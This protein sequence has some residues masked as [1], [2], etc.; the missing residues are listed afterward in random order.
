[1]RSY[2]LFILLYI[3]FQLFSQHGI[4]QSSAHSGQFREDSSSFYFRFDNTNFFKNNEFFNDYVKG[5][6]LIGWYANPS[7]KWKVSEKTQLTGG[8]HLLKYLGKGKIQDVKPIFRVEQNLTDSLRLIMGN[9]F[10]NQNHSLID[11]LYHNEKAL[12][13]P[14]ETGIQFLMEHK[15]IHADI[16]LNWKN[17]ILQNSPTQEEFEVGAQ[18]SP[19]IISGRKLSVEIPVQFL[20]RHRGGQIDISGEPIQSV[21]N[22]ALG[23]SL[24]FHPE[25]TILSELRAESYMALYKDISQKKQLPYEQGAGSYSRIS[26][27]LKKWEV[28]I[29]YWNAKRFIPLAGNPIYSTVSRENQHFTHSRELITGKV[30]Y[31]YDYKNA[32][33]SFDLRTYVDPIHQNLDYS[34]GLYLKLSPEIFINKF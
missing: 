24:R 17:F 21:M 18:L 32:T 25:S 12:T 26:A 20:A 6:T 1:M 14:V 9:I 2:L 13:E 16:W 8:I 30:Q 29:S 33:L 10:Q 27:T 22:M 3:P 7:L 11:P 28:G 5:Y 34:F 23:S 19:K 4:T 31:K 15:I